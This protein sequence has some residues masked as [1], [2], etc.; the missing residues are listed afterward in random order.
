MIKGSIKEEDITLI[1]IYA[2]NIWVP[3]YIKEILTY[4]KVEIDSNRIVVN[5]NTP[6]TSMDR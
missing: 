2:P 1:N 5:F 6:L 4:I 3:K